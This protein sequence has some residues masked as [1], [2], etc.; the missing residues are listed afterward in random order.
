MMYEVYE[1]WEQCEITSF[2]PL[3]PVVAPRFIYITTS[4]GQ[5]MSA[6]KSSFS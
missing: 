6:M 5:G 1:E 2:T 3:D 4:L